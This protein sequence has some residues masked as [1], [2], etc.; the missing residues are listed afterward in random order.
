MDDFRE[1]RKNILVA[2]DIAQEGLDIQKCNY[3]IRYDFVSNE[4]GQVQSRGR[5]RADKGK[6]YL[7]TFDRS[8]N[9]NRE[10]ENR[11]KEKEMDR[12]I[13]KFMTE[14]KYTDYVAK[15]NEEKVMHS[16]IYYLYFNVSVFNLFIDKISANSQK[17]RGKS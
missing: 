16:C 7:I 5:A 17:E 10:L 6:C 3:V 15:F 9:H 1:G 14:K 13:H 11:F 4:I 12:A 2:T 8:I